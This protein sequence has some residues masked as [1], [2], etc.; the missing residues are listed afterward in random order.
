MAALLMVLKI[1]DGY[2]WTEP[3]TGIWGIIGSTYRATAYG[4]NARTFPLYG[5]IWITQKFLGGEFIPSPSF[6]ECKVRNHG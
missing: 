3:V 1:R 2:A 6:I 4:R 5:S